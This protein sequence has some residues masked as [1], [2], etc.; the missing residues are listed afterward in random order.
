MFCNC[1]WPKAKMLMWMDGMVCSVLSVRGDGTTGN[2]MPL[3]D[4][5]PRPEGRAWHFPDGN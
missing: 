3:F 1:D 2:S 4:P 5:F